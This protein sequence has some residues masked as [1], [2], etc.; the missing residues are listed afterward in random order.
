MVWRRTF[1]FHGVWGRRG[2]SGIRPRSIKISGPTLINQRSEKN[3]RGLFRKRRVKFSHTQTHTHS[4]TLTITHTHTHTGTLSLSFSLPPSK[5]VFWAVR[6][7]LMSHRPSIWV[8]AAASAQL[9]M[10]IVREGN[11]FNWIIKEREKKQMLAHF[12]AESCQCF[13]IRFF[14]SIVNCVFKW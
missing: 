3:W 8:S 10:T 1:H 11:R 13:E 2:C 5:K 6:D 14:S 12:G 4:L 9:K 7:D